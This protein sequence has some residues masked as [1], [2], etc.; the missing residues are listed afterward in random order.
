MVI[1]ELAG[2]TPVQLASAGQK[3]LAV[4][5]REITKVIATITSQLEELDDSDFPVKG[6]IG[7]SS[8]GGGDLSPLVAGHHARAHAVV[9]DTLSEVKS[10]LESFRES[11]RDARDLLQVKDQEAEADVKVILGQTEGID[12]G[13]WAYQDAQV[14]NRD[15]T[16][17]EAPIEA[18]T[19][20]TTTEES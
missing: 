1:P 6:H 16:P 5:E 12:M 17:T 20:S 10:D 15:V 14:N 13:K 8:F 19:A 3:G 18:S 7:R 2:F 9:V 11:I 4:A